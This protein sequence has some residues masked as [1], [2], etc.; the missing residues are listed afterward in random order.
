MPRNIT[1]TFA[2]GTTHVYQNAPDNITPEVVSARAQKD[3][4]KQV[5]SLDGGRGGAPKPTPAT[6]PKPRESWGSSLLES[7]KYVGSNA[8]KGLASPI[9]MAMEAGQFVTDGVSNV[10]HGAGD[11]VL[12][13]GGASQN[14]INT[15]DR[16]MTHRSGIPNTVSGAIDRA[17]TPS[18][19]H[20]P[21]V[22]TAAQLA[23]GMLFPGASPSKPTVRAPVARAAAKPPVNALLQD[24][25][26]AGVRVMTS[27]VKPP[28]TF[29]GKSAQA[30]GERIPY[31]GTGPARQA[32]QAERIAAVKGLLTDFNAPE[33]GGIIDQVATD[34][35]KTRGNIITKLTNAK[36]S[37]IQ[38]A[39]GAVN[40]PQAVSAIDAQIANLAGINADKYAPIIKELEGFKSVLTSGKTLDQIE[41]NRK[42]LGDLFKDPSLAAIAGD[43]QKALNAIYGPLRADMG[44]HIKTTLGNEAMLRW[45]SANKQLSVM[46]GE[47]GNSAFKSVLSKAETSPEDVAR[48]LF[49]KK[50][51]DV[52]RLFSN[53][54]IDGRA[55][56]QSAVLHKAMQDAGGVE[57]LSPDRFIGSVNK[58]GRTVGVIFDP[59]D[60]TRIEGLSRVLGAT[61]RA[62]EASIAPPTG[63]QNAI[64]ILSAVLTDMMGGAGAAITS[65]GLIGLTARAYESAPVRNALLKVARAPKGSKIEAQMIE[66][67]GLAIASVARLHA[68]E[69][70]AAMNDNA[71]VIASAGNRP[72]DQQ[73]QQPPLNP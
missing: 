60:L 9:D 54:S 50:P 72:E 19:T 66:R 44:N 22:A 42:L 3:F 35:A 25:Q 48:L 30:I 12:R 10:L 24:A 38:G 2:D 4:G 5:Q 33:A 8:L 6:K 51:S 45:Q 15:F 61:K 52:R 70:K 32:Q 62:A 21:G 34:F 37:V 14:T 63:A 73:E 59:T 57:N 36:N 18:G 39:P 11:A 41:G 56:A 20:A 71:G 31:A 13:A 64:P 69:I 46:A 29:V 27:D 53:L 49:S 1:V 26:S 43:G 47:L 55:K 16:A 17:Y 40:T 23:G 28:R 58:L 7:A 67:A 65:G 68:A